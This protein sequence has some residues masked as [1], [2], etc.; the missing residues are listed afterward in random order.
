MKKRSR[1]LSSVLVV[2]ALAFTLGGSALAFQDLKDEPAKDKIMALLNEGI[3]KGVDDSRFAPKEKMTYAQSVQM[4]VNGLDLNLDTVKFVKKPEATDYYTNI[5]NNA[6]YAEAFVIAQIN[7]LSIPKDIDPAKKITRE[8][9]ANLL[10]EAMWTKGDFA[11]IEIW[12]QID[13][14]DSIDNRYMTNIQRLLIAKV[15]SLDDKQRFRPLDEITRAEAAAMLHDARKFVK[16][17]AGNVIP[18]LPPAQHE[19][20]T[21]SVGKISDEVNKVTLS[22]GEKPNPG[23]RITIRSI[24]FSEQGKAVI[25]YEL[26]YPDPNMNYAQVIVE[27]KAETYLS[28]KLEAEIAFAGAGSKGFGGGSSS[29]SG[30]SDASDSSDSSASQSVSNM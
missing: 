6:W 21:V 19:D 2:L 11:F 24:D 18:K 4:I 27:P 17:Q 22:W 30:S 15:A 20:V 3:V 1:V 5:P 8:Q 25:Y 12:I 7:G 13:D 9:F 28:A 10:A 23:Y 26:H 14:E 29:S 16:E